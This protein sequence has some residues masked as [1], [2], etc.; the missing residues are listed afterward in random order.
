MKKLGDSTLLFCFGNNSFISG[1]TLIGTSHLYW[2]LT[3]PSFA[4]WGTTESG[5]KTYRACQLKEENTHTGIILRKA[6]TYEG[7]Q[8][9]VGISQG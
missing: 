9:A 1:N 6:H 4:M 3:S 5:G 7:E 8:S 2:I